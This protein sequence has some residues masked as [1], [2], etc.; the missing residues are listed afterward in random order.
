MPLHAPKL[1]FWG[2]DRLN[3]ELH[4]QNPKRHILACKDVILPIDRQIRST[5]VTYARAHETK[6]DKER[7]LSV[8]KW[9]FAQTTNVVRSKYRLACMVSGLPAVVIIFKFH[10]H[11][12]SGYRSVRGRISEN[13][14]IT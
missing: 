2:F 14:P 9:L 4:Q 7:N 10:Q 11:R 8:A 6:K 13:D 5:G 3:A 1:W 12:L